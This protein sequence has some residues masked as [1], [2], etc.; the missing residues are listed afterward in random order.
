[1]SKKELTQ[2][3][4]TL[5]ATQPDQ[6]VFVIN[7]RTAE[8]RE[9]EQASQQFAKTLQPKPETAKPRTFQTVHEVAEVLNDREHSGL[10]FK[11]GRTLPKGYQ[12]D[13]RDVPGR[14]KAAQRRLKQLEKQGRKP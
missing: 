9:A 7:S 5:L 11:E 8:Q 2:A 12:W 10:R 4:A 3:L 14:G 1:M 6:R 13:G